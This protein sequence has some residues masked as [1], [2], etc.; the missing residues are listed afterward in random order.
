MFSAKVVGKKLEITTDDPSV[1]CYLKGELEEP[2]YNIWTKKFGTIKK[3][4]TIFDKR[5]GRRVSG[6]LFKYTL[7]LGWAG[8]VMNV[9]S[10]LIS[11]EDYN[12]IKASLMSD[13]YRDAP[14]P[15]LRDYQND[16]MLFLL[17]Y[18]I[19]LC[20]TNTS[21]GKTETISTLANYFLSQGKKVIMI[22]PGSKARDELVKR[23]K[24]RFGIEVS[25]NLGD[26]ICCIITSG[27][28]NK[29]DYKT[30]EGL[31][32]AT[33]ALASY[34]VALVDEVEYTINPGGE[35]LYSRLVN[36]TNFYG[37]SGTA[38]KYTGT[39]I[40]FNNGLDEVTL[41]N[42]EMIKHFGPALIFRL[43]LNLKIDD[44]VIKT[45]S[46]DLLQLDQNALNNCGNI[47]NELM[48]QIW[49]DPEV[50]KSLVRIIKAYPKT[51]I[52][53]NNLNGV[54][55][56]WIDNFFVG[57]LR[58]LLVS[59]EGYSY[60]DLDGSKTNLSLQEACDY[61]KQGLVDVIPSTSS[62]YRALDF[63]GLEN[64]ILVAGKVAGVTLQ[65]IGRVARGSHMN[66]ITLA[67]HSGRKIP[68]YSKGA[69]GRDEM[70]K[71][72]YKYCDIESWTIDE[73]YL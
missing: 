66:I 8:Y 50:C 26:P 27:I 25:T 57:E 54:I 58:V 4:V 12:G 13:N 49:T 34:Q 55:K 18:K 63:P 5:G 33:E 2:G 42:R 65:C 36:T 29:G 41:K 22:T 9:F 60:Y 62:G 53:L 32:K 10:K 71:Q 16:D 68:I 52:P 15:N 21:Y 67:P 48:N 43:P 14:F 47:Y 56:Y 73:T 70:L 46:L 24:I 7:G 28:S 64:I 19:G 35:F 69:E 61:I 38:D 45:K 3:T 23:C 59:G 31:K 30:D 17:K 20:Q 39:A 40:T 1:E 51:F 11:I 6:G 44:I 72:Y 37:F